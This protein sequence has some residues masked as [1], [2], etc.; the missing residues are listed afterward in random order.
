MIISILFVKGAQHLKRLWSLR[1]GT[2]LGIP[3]L[4]IIGIPG[5]LRFAEPGAEGKRAVAGSPYANSALPQGSVEKTGTP[6][7]CEAFVGEEYRRFCLK[8]DV[9]V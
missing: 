3:G 2:H 8:L 9:G 6:E 7:K 5:P 1:E 4:I